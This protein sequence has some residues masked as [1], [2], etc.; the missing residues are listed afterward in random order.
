MT[1]DV[2]L[3]LLQQRFASI[4]YSN[5]VRYHWSARGTVRK[6]RELPISNALTSITTQNTSIVPRNPSAGS[7]LPAVPS[8]TPK[9]LEL[10]H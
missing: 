4:R 9:A 5:D 7:K 3:P 1:K 8:R 2:F 6:P 10:A